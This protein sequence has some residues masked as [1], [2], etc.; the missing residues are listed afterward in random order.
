[1]KKNTTLTPCEARWGAGGK[2]VS[3]CGGKRVGPTRCWVG[4]NSPTETRE[5]I[6]LG[7]A[8]KN[9]CFLGK[10]SHNPHLFKFPQQKKNKVLEGWKL[11]AN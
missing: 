10:K 6:N 9:C 3:G 11:Q 7:P 8:K 2:V 5:K 1:M 4:Q